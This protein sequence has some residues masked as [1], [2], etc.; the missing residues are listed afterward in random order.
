MARME[1]VKQTSLVAG[2]KGTRMR[3]K[4][5]I[6]IICSHLTVEIKYILNMSPLK[7]YLDLPN[8]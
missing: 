4:L 1:R 8:L 3:L 6:K 2:S 7:L 5:Y